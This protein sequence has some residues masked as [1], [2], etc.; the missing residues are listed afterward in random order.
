[1]MLGRG[2]GGASDDVCCDY[3]AACLHA[4]GIERVVFETDLNDYTCCL[5]FQ[6]SALLAWRV[7]P[8]W[9]CLVCGWGWVQRKHG[10]SVRWVALMSGRRVLQMCGVIE[11]E[12]RT[13]A[14][15]AANVFDAQNVDRDLL[16]GVVA[17]AA[18]RTAKTETATAVL[19][20]ACGCCVATR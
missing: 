18:E 17:M 2:K 10:T 4:C 3:C 5:S 19:Q 15:L 12:R 1:M 8:W 9:Y 16:K 7:D 20:M 14:V 11:R 13:R 6:A